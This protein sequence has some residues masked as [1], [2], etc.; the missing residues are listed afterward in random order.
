MKITLAAA[1]VAAALSIGPA[2]AQD[3]SPHRTRMVTVDGD[4]RLEVLDWGGAGR[5]V[6]V[7]AGSGNSAH[8]FDDFAPKLAGRCC[9]VYGIT[10]RGYGASSQPASGY[11]E[12]R[13]ADD[14]LEV[15][16]ALR[17]DKPVLVGHS[18]AGGEMTILGAQ[19]S[20]RLGGLVYLDALFDPG[21]Y[22]ASDPAYMAL[23]KRQPAMRP[24]PPP[25]TPEESRSFAAYRARQLRVEG[26]AFPESEYRSVYETNPDGSKGRYKTPRRIFDAIG[27]GQKARDYSRI[28]VPV[29]S[30]NDTPNTPGD[31]GTYHPKDDEDRAAIDAF[32][33][34]TLAFLER[35][36]T[37]LRSAVP[38]ARF[39]DLPG[40]GHYLFLTRENSVLEETRKFVEALQ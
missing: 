21:N 3:T 22:P 7:L 40:A 29:L 27:A 30:F 36:K 16:D 34:A 17:I 14:I 28:R 2:R 12:Q 20:D 15:L 9:H 18:M 11:D 33:A 38:S 4:I 6:V 23:A 39:V 35:W 24:P 19:H 26:F 13:L 31:Y 37:N 5:P 32:R 25:P 10:R 8:V 1:A